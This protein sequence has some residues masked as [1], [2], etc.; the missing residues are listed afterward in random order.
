MTISA[1]IPRSG[2]YTGDGSTQAFSYN[3]LIDTETEIEVVLAD[4]AGIETV[5]TLTTHYTVSGVGSNAGGTV[6]F[7][8]APAAGETVSVRRVTAQDQGV[9]LQNRGAVVPEVLEAAFDETVKMVQDLQEQV[10]RSITLRLTANT[11]G[12]TVPAPE[13][14]K[15]VGWNAA[16]TNLENKTPN[17]GDFLTLPGGS[18]DNRVVRFDGTSGDALKESAVAIDDGGNV[19]GVGTLG[20]SDRVTITN[21]APQLRLVDSDGSGRADITAD[22][23]NGLILD[24]DPTNE[25]ANTRLLVNVDSNEALRVSST[26]ILIGGGG[27]DPALS[28][29]MGAK[30][31]AIQLPAGTTAQRPTGSA[32]R[33]RFNSTTSE[34]EGHDGSSWGSVGGGAGRFKG[35]NGERGSNVGAGDI[36]RVHEQELNTDTT[37]DADENALAAGPLTVAGGVTLTVTSGGNVSIV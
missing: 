12:I 7:V 37:I 8:T 17:S 22:D 10:S 14:N 2:P 5:Q 29:D 9:D 26:G 27:G 1:T 18:N 6:T 4:V 36:F 35:E 23:G 30:T 11:V 28:L 3:F 19:S 24:L 34:F 13:A 20:A 15:I 25:D 21:A 16:G 31:D 32:G 33:F